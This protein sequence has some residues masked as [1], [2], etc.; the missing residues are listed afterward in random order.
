VKK[1]KNMLF[2]GVCLLFLLAFCSHIQSIDCT[3][4]YF[5]ERFLQFINESTAKHLAKFQRS[6]EFVSKPGQCSELQTQN[7]EVLR[8]YHKIPYG[9]MY[10]CGSHPEYANFVLVSR[11]HSQSNFDYCNS[12]NPEAF[13][14]LIRNKSI[15]F[16]GDSLVR[17][18]FNGVTGALLKYQT[19]FYQDGRNY[20]NHYYRDFQIN[21]SYCDDGFGHAAIHG[22]RHGDY[23]LC[24]KPMMDSVDYMILGFAAWYKPFFAI[25]PNHE[26]DFYRNLF[27]S[28]A[29]YQRELVKIRERIAQYPSSSRRNPRPIRV[30]WRLSPHASNIDELTFL[31]GANLSSNYNHH[32]GL[33]WSQN[34]TQYSA[35]WAGL[36]N[37]VQRNISHS[38]NDLI[39]DWHSLSLSYMEKFK[40]VYYDNEDSNNKFRKDRPIH[41]DSLH[42]CMETVP[43]AANFLLLELLRKAENAVTGG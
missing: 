35:G 9:V 10:N 23:N 27:L 20:F 18:V 29:H 40:E 43:T 7:A 19:T 12:W 8:N 39:L 22:E 25:N 24:L 15:A 16:Y 14:S 1:K 28:Y 36:Y 6:F 26:K 33:L 41:A 17:Q 42:Y 30:I 21:I 2:G 4:T 13:L 34:F 5:P 11:N 38:Y 37:H 31:H 3:N 32:N